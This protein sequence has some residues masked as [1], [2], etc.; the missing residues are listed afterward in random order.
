LQTQPLEAAAIRAL[1]RSRLALPGSP[2]VL[3]QLGA[4]GRRDAAHLL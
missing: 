3:L 4:P 1:I 2:Q